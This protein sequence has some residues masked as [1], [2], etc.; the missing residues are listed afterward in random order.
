MVTVVLFGVWKSMGYYMVIYLAGLQGINHDL[1][2]A[3]S[4]DGA[5]RLAEASGT[6]RCRNSGQR[7]SSSP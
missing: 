4:I 7:P 6:S 1:Y 5:R 2:E 3:A